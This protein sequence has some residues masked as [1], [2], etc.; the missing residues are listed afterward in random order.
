MNCIRWRSFKQSF[1]KGK[2]NYLETKL[3]SNLDIDISQLCRLKVSAF[4]EPYIPFVTE[5]QA[6]YARQLQSK[7]NNCKTISFLDWES[8]SMNLSDRFHFI[9]HCD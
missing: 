9:N 2:V 1:H 3:K 6:I 4:G 5:F 8:F 7:L